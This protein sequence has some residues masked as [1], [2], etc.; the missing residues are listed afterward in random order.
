MTAAIFA[1]L[2]GLAGAYA[3]RQYLQQ[4]KPATETVAKPA[5]EQVIVP[6]AA[7]ELV[8]GQRL[9]L[10][11]IIVHRLTREAF[12]KS[13][14]AK[15]IFMSNTR[16]I[17]GRVLRVGLKQGEV[18]EPTE[19]YPDGMGPG[20]ADMLEEG[21]RAVTVPIENVGAVEGFAQ[22]GSIVDVLFRSKPDD[23]E[24]AVTIT[25][26][27][28]VQVLAI[29]QAML[30]NQ[31]VN[32]KDRASQQGTVTLAVTPVQAKALK[33]VQDRGELS[34]ALRNPNDTAS[35]TSIVRSSKGLT[36]AQ[37]LGRPAKKIAQMDIFRGGHKETLEFPNRAA[38]STDN[39]IADLL[40]T[41][42]AGGPRSSVGTSSHG[43][44]TVG[45]KHDR[46]S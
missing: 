4:P 31:R 29:G 1:I 14:F 30:P 33:V 22:P 16:Q 40:E 21:Y 20:I 41:P 8:K 7:R 18:F 25:L 19:F 2:V 6:V 44:D 35:L 39:P 45:A 26:L 3:V 10:D 43:D 42:I 17:A 27:E 15:K 28:R 9:T 11:D 32:L 34:L 46:G 37:L 36:L 13:P 23:N 38:G 24:P 12:G 5:P